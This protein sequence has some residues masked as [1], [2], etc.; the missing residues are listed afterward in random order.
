[1]DLAAI[2]AKFYLSISLISDTTVAGADLKIQKLAK[3]DGSMLFS[4]DLSRVVVFSIGS[5]NEGD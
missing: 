3:K 5:W 2:I 1:V 4:R